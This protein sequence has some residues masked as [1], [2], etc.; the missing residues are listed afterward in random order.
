VV[1]NA[2]QSQHNAAGTT[3]SVFCN[4]SGEPPGTNKVTKRVWHG[5]REAIFA[6]ASPVTHGNCK[7]P[8]SAELMSTKASGLAAADKGAAATCGFCGARGHAGQRRGEGAG[9]G[10]AA[11]SVAQR[12]ADGHP[13][14]R[15]DPGRCRRRVWG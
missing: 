10:Q 13:E 6:A 9:C 3:T 15:N 4:R 2:L 7:V 12:H 1:F 5:R 11:E 14:K 8:R